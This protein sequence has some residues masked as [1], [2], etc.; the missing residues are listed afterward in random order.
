MSTAL[1]SS[2]EREMEQQKATCDI[3]KNLA[4]AYETI[5]GKDVEIRRMN[6]TMNLGNGKNNSYSSKAPLAE[7]SKQRNINIVSTS[8]VVFI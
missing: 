7:L 3:A 8:R 1:S 6:T 4:I 2:N 5:I